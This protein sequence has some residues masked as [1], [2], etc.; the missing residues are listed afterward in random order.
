MQ[1]TVDGAVTVDGKS[2]VLIK[3]TKAPFQDKLVLPGGHVEETDATLVEACVRE[4]EEEIGLVVSVSR[5][6]QLVVLNRVG[7]D[8]RYPRRLSVAFHVDI[9]ETEYRS[10]RAGS[11]ARELVLCDLA[12]LTPNEVGFDHFDAVEALREHLV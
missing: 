9:S 4:L 11:D 2:L 5:L 1:I 10:L 3:R 8:P 12:T 7:A 6:R